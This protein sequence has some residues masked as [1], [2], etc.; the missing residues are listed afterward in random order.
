MLLLLVVFGPFH[1]AHVDIKLYSPWKDID[2]NSFYKLPQDLR[3]M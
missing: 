3:K 1:K 2:N